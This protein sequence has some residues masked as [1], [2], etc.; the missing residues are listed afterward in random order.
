[1]RNL[2][3]GDCAVLNEGPYIDE[4]VVAL[5][6]VSAGWPDTTTR[7]TLHCDSRIRSCHA[8]ACLPS[9]R[10]GFR[11]NKADLALKP[12]AYRS[13]LGPYVREVWDLG[14]LSVGIRGR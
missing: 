1:M 5:D 11:L 13:D 9:R 8:A 10:T 2:G 4:A 7:R 3:R 12:P 14:P 6:E